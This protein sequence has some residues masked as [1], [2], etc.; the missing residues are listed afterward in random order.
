MNTTR[1]YAAEYLAARIE[2]HQARDLQSV[3]L[4]VLEAAEVRAAA[5][6]DAA[7]DAGIN[8]P[9]IDLDEQARLT[10]YPDAPRARVR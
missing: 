6:D 5:I 1:D 10:I 7:Y 2:V 8:L 3:P 9:L 4:S